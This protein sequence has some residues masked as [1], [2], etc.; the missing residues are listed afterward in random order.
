MSIGTVEQQI[1]YSVFLMDRPLM[2]HFHNV[3]TAVP[4]ELIWTTPRA[5]LNSKLCTEPLAA[6]ICSLSHYAH[7]SWRQ[8][9]DVCSSDGL[10]VITSCQDAGDRVFSALLD[11]DPFG[12]CRFVHGVFEHRPGERVA[13]AAERPIFLAVVVS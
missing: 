10:Q 3:D 12:F 13:P 5:I 6:A 9:G 4:D 7:V 1:H 11:F 8:D 2:I